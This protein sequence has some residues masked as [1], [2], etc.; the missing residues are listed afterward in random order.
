[1]GW[2]YGDFGRAQELDRESA[3]IGHRIKNGN[4]EISALINIGFDT[5]H[6]GDPGRALGL[7]EET[8]VRAEKAFGAHRWRWSMHL[9]FGLAL[10]LQALQRD[11]EAGAQAARGLRQAEET[12]S[13]KYVGWFHQVQGDLA[14]RAS[15][16]ARAVDELQ[17]ALDVA[18]RIGYPTLTWQSA[19]LLARACAADGRPADALSA[20]TLAVETIERM[21]TGAPD[22]HYRQTLLAWP[23]VQA[24]YETLEQLRRHT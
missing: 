17:H 22:P 16:P 9:R 23:R 2:L 4:V 24:V 1:M 18:R 10:A 20:A 7:F 21:E 3:D 5:F 6:L 13:K 12:G 8:L 19:H 11:G 14:L 15:Q